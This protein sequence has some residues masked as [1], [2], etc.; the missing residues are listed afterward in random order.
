MRSAVKEQIQSLGAKF[1]EVEGSGDAEAAGGYAR[2]LTAEEQERQ[3]E[4]L[5][6]R[7]SPSPTSIITTA[8]VPGPPGAEARHGRRRR[9]A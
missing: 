9:A 5:D 6:G 8:L 2:E 4:A 7:R 3:R 1:L